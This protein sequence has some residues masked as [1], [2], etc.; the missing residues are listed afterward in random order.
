MCNNFK[1]VLER[2]SN[3][4]TNFATTSPLHVQSDH[5]QSDLGVNVAEIRQLIPI[6]VQKVNFMILFVNQFV[7]AHRAL[8]S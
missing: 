4:A 5:V 1:T 7:A 8:T 2:M 6:Q 3:I